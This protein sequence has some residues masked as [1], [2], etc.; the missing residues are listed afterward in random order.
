M[1]LDE[2]ITILEDV[3]YEF[4]R[5]IDMEADAYYSNTI[6]PNNGKSAE[7]TWRETWGKDDAELVDKLTQVIAFLE[8]Q[9]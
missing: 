6:K 9:E 7:D 4:N 1:Q 5:K 8:G 2:I 3:R